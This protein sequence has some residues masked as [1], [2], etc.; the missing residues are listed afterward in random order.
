VACDVNLYPEEMA[1][2]IATHVL[3]HLAHADKKGRTQQGAAAGAGGGGGGVGE[4]ASA[5][6]ALL[7]LT[8]KF[9][10]KPTPERLAAMEERIAHILSEGGKGLGLA[11]VGH[12]CVW[13]HANSANERTLLAVVGAAAGGRGGGE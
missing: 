4:G 10:G 5:A 1:E 3:P 9:P 2:L 11:V 13:L 12:R 7:A 6:G 8:L